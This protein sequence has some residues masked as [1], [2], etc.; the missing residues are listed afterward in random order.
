MFVPGDQSPQ[1]PAQMLR[2]PKDW[3]PHRRQV[4]RGLQCKVLIREPHLYECREAGLAGG[5][6]LRSPEGLASP[7][8]ARCQ[9]CPLGCPA[10]GSGLDL[11]LRSREVGSGEGVPWAGSC[12]AEAGSA[13]AGSWRPLAH[14]T[15]CARPQARPWRRSW[16]LS[17]RGPDGILSPRCFSL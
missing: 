12:A 6:A 8:G 11:H 5:V 10:W 4:S 9:C 17:S 2:S 14:P 3:S 7:G 13:G 1:F 15:P 16:W